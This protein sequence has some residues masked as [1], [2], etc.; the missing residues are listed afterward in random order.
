MFNPNDKY[1]KRAKKE[2]YRAR[3][4]FKLE[5]INKKFK[6]LKPG[7]T[8]LDLGAAPGSWLQY[9]RSQVGKRG[10]VIGIDHEPITPLPF[11]NIKIFLNDISTIN[12]L[13]KFPSN[14]DLVLSDL[15]P[16]TSGTKFADSAKSLELLIQAFRIA[17]KFLK[18]D[19]HFVGKVF[20]SEE[21]NQ[22]FNEFSKS[23]TLAKRY[24]PHA[25]RDSS[26][27]LYFIGKNFKK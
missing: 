24:K 3:A 7:D 11:K 14:F 5:E 25:C 26:K 10:L 20:V 2:G 13:D 23:F 16:A 21:L 9:I 22:F 1:T 6:L 18:N 4:V 15:A 8:V 19:G 27:E 17:K 12:K